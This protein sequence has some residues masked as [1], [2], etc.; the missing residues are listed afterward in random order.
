MA[1][2]LREASVT[3]LYG[4]RDLQVVIPAEDSIA[5]I[6]GPNGIG[7]ST[8]LRLLLNL[9]TFNFPSLARIPFESATV[10]LAADDAEDV[11]VEVRR[12]RDAWSLEV[13][14]DGHTWPIEVFTAAEE[15]AFTRYLEE[16]L[17]ELVLLPNGRWWDER[18]AS[19]YTLREVLAIVAER[20]PTGSAGRL[21]YDPSLA[22]AMPSIDVEYIGADR[23]RNDLAPLLRGERDAFE[24][25]GEAGSGYAGA[26][27]S[28]AALFRHRRALAHGIAGARADAAAVARSLDQTFPARLVADAGRF[29]LTGPELVESFAA[30]DGQYAELARVGL[31]E[32]VVQ[33]EPELPDDAPEWMRMA[34]TLWL[35]DAQAKLEP[36]RALGTRIELFLR[37]ARRKLADKD[38]EVNARDGFVIRTAA[39]YELAPTALSSGEQHQL[40]L[41]YRMIFRD[42]GRRLFL[43]DEPEISLHVGWQ[44]EFVADLVEIAGVNDSQFL[45]ATHS[46]LIIGERYDLLVDVTGADS[47]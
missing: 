41:L 45:L 17:P 22:Q 38:F 46:P 31:V 42:S 10:T 35:S 9:L 24:L 37:L 13:T 4:D 7:K 32:D 29:A 40:L 25:S 30:L 3:G 11:L 2:Y 47:L 43:I 16:F 23:L 27:G 8:L 33:A 28:T 18:T 34:L 26:G 21:G 39:G 19:E 6:H 20:A 1:T 36:L 14:I 44:E 15:R 12:A 5:F